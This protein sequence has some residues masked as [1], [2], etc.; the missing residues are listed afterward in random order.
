[1]TT[2]TPGVQPQAQPPP[3]AAPSS[4]HAATAGAIA[5]ANSGGEPTTNTKIGSMEDLKKKAPK[6]YQKMLEGI[7]M[8]ICNDMKEH[9]DRVKE[10]Q[11]KG[12]AQS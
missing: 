9:Q 4:A 5:S 6:L 7:A 3:V 8:A 2:P 12:N 1:M 10:L 11:R